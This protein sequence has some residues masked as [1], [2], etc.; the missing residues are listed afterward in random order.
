MFTM[1]EYIVEVSIN[2]AAFLADVSRDCFDVR[3]SRII[4]LYDESLAVI[5]GARY[6]PHIG[7][8]V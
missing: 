4:S 1:A 8:P 7:N 6:A 5:E 3:V 2:A